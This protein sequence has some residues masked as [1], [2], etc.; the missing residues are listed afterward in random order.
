VFDNWYTDRI[1]GTP[2]D[3][4]TVVTGDV[5][6][7]AHWIGVVTFTNNGEVALD[8]GV[9]SSFQYSGKYLESVQ[10]L[11]FNNDFEIV[12]NAT[13]GSDVSSNQ[14]VFGLK[15]AG[16][17]TEFGALRGKFMWELLGQGWEQDGAIYQGTNDIL[18]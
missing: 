2:I 13:T 6:Y 12:I 5:T 4:N 10:K 7:Y 16:T 1:G 3:R 14:E 18:P 17:E 8:N 11:D 9:A 15:Q